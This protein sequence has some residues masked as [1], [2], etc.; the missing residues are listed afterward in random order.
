MLELRRGGF[1]EYLETRTDDIERVPAADPEGMCILPGQILR[2]NLQD[3]L[4]RSG[5]PTAT[6]AHFTTIEDLTRDLLA[7]EDEPTNVLSEGVRRQLVASI[8]KEMDPAPQIPDDTAIAAL[9][10]NSTVL[11]GS[12]RDALR[13]VAERLPYHDDDV[14]EVVVEEFDDYY[15]CTDA[16]EEHSRLLDIVASGGFGGE[17]ELNYSLRTIRAFKAIDT[18]AHEQ[19]SAFDEDSQLSRSHLVRNGRTVIDNAWPSRYDHVEWIAVGGISV[20]DNPTLRF[21]HQL[22]E[23][24]TAPDVI[25]FSGQGSFEYNRDRLQH[26]EGARIEDD[27]VVTTGVE[28]D[29]ASKLFESAVGTAADFPEN[30]RLVEAPSDRRSVEHIASE[31]REQVQAGAAP[32]DFLIVAPDAGAYQTLLEDAFETVGIPVHV[33]TRRPT[34]NVPAYRFIRDFVELVW[35]AERDDR[36]T[37]G[38]LVDP[39]RLGYCNPSAQRSWPVK[40]RDF[41]TI[42]ARL[43]REQQQWHDGPT[44]TADQGLRLEEWEQV[45]EE[46]PSWT[47]DWNAVDVL[48]EDVRERTGNPPQSGEDLIDDF[49]SYL[50]TYVWETID[51]QR[52]L[53]KGPGIDNTRVAISE[54]HV[55]SLAEHVRREFGSVGR[56]YD[57]AMDLFDRAASWGLVGEVLSAGLGGDTYAEQHLDGNAVPVVDAGNSY[58]RDAEHVYI[59]GLNAEEFPAGQDIPT[60]LHSALRQ[61]ITELAADGEEPFFHLDSRQTAYGES[62]DFYQASLATATEDANLTLLHTYRDQRGNEVSWSAFVDLFETEERAIHTRVGEYLPEPRESNGQGNGDAHGGSGDSDGADSGETWAELSARISPR[63]RLRT[64]LY[65]ANRDH[66][67]TQPTIDSD[68]VQALLDDLDYETLRD[69]I[70]PRKERFHDPPTT[71]DISPDEPAFDDTPLEEVIGAPLHP[72]ELDL[73]SQC[74]LKYHYYQLLYNFEGDSPDRETI[75]YYSSSRPH[76][77]LSALPRVVRDNYA[78]PRNV[79][80]WRQII[81]DLLPERQ[82]ADEGLLQFESADDLKSWFDDQSIDDFN[83]MLLDNLRRERA[84]V[85]EEAAQD[86]DR[87]WSWR[88]REVIEVEGHRVSVPPHRVDHVDTG[89]KQYSIPIFYGR[90]TERAQSALKACFKGD[91]TS[92]DIFGEEDCET[93]CEWCGWDDCYFDSKYVLDHRVF[94]GYEQEYEEYDNSVMGIGI[95]EAWADQEGSRHLTV[96]TNHAGKLLEASALEHITPRGYSNQWYEEKVPAWRG[97]LE[98]HADALAVDGG[99][100]LQA[101]QDLVDDEC[102][103]CVYKDLCFVPG[104]D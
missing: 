83:D 67:D 71:L 29:G 94:L 76:H 81:T 78:D 52:E 65:H 14:L 19:L 18:L 37:Y 101:N 34:A 44:A 25:L 64:T 63:E 17:F 35:A 75:P 80:R 21:L 74:G 3:H 62:V 57:Q 46:I 47:S 15:R 42:E 11:T 91:D 61:H 26:I 27:G 8:M 70:Q 48:L 50:G 84:L 86:I 5:Y 88:D 7:E 100:S 90:I 23:T 54:T 12:Q 6:L 82:D 95:Q 89:D 16:G 38:E 66:P 77:R 79:E 1:L 53:F 102:L 99:V 39:L 22:S 9:D 60:F 45:L 97:D 20:F 49:G 85:F 24:P 69:Q 103:N 4:D 51:H 104:G 58:F 36:I 68:D 2:G 13:E 92:E 40:G 59:L 10:V 72:Q 98:A 93:I 56:L 28:N 31:V 32:S 96:K 41:T 30:A 73:Y 43:H 33:E 87:T 55:T